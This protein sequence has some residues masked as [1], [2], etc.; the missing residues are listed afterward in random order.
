[1]ADTST[2]PTPVGSSDFSRPSGP[3]AGESQGKDMLN[4]V[5]DSAHSAVDRLAD[6]AAPAVQKLEAGVAQASD[7]L[8]EQ[9]HH[10]RERGD[11]WTH[12]MRETVRR[13]PLSSVVLAFAVGA[14]VA[15]VT[16]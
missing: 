8:H 14:L 4:R 16:R 7:A 2:R 15:R 10:L 1:M 12:S 3:A 5:T 13:H 9:A 6:K 11:E